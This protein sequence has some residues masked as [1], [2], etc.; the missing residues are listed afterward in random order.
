MCLR[1][2]CG[3]RELPTERFH[4]YTYA[5]GQEAAQTFTAPE[6]FDLVTVELPIARCSADTPATTN[7]LVRIRAVDPVTREPTNTVLATSATV[8]ATDIQDLCSG[9][10]AT[11]LDG[12]TF[13]FNPPLPL[14]AGTM[15]AI[16]LGAP[17]TSVGTF[18]WQIALDA[19]VNYSGGTVHYPVPGQWPA[20]GS[21]TIDF[22]FAARGNRTCP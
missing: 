3:F 14:S 8:V 20:D 13:T 9:P 17:G 4:P 10:N 18:F 19:G 21:P 7:A 11:T 6:G 5:N 2:W 16:E 15:Y 1:H 22:G 12:Q